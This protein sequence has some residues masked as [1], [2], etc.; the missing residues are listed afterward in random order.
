MKKIIITGLLSLFIFVLSACQ[1]EKLYTLNFLDYMDTF[2]QVQVSA[3]S[4]SKAKEHRENIDAIF[5]LYHDFSTAYEPLSLSSEYL[6][7][8]YS[9]NLKKDQKLEIDEELYELLLYAEELKEV[10]YGY[11]DISIGKAVDVWKNTMDSVTDDFE[12]GEHVYVY[13]YYEGERIEENKVDVYA[14][15]EVV[16]VSRD[17]EDQNIV[18]SVS[19]DVNEE[20]I[21]IDKNDVY[22]KEMPRA[23]YN[24][25]IEK[26]NSLDF[27]E[28]EIILE[29]ENGKFYV[30]I[31]GDDIKLD[32]GALSKGYATQKVYEYLFDQDMRF[33]SISSGT[34]S[35]IVGENSKRSDEDYVY[36]I[37]LAN[38]YKLQFT[39]KATYGTIHVK[40]TSITTSG[41][42]EQ[43]VLYEGQRYHHIVSPFSKMPE[44][45]Y[46]T[47]TVLG[48]DAGLLDALSTA[49]FSMSPDVME[50]WLEEYQDVYNIEIIRFNQDLSIDTYLKDTIFEEH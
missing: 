24:D 37:S 17:E 25:S 21:T 3:N 40:N 31:Q 29:S 32:L 50:S 33:Y 46:H 14:T 27:T 38:P 41:N 49:F 12:I 4:E 5:S 34:S 13:Y 16:F 8:V 47:V 45:H 39:D 15:G 19:L 6:E 1:S 18:L 7:N 28:N 10:T 42:Y 30:T 22:R 9:I 43:Y 2:I 35:I 44:Q 23:I 26:I 36:Y 20:I 11:F 48:A